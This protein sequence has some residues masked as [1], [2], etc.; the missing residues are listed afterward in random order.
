MMRYGLI[1]GNGRFPMLTLESARKLGH[2]VI[3]IGIQEEASREIEKLATPGNAPRRPAVE[4][5]THPIASI[6]YARTPEVVTFSQGS[7]QLRPVVNGGAFIGDGLTVFN[8][9]GLDPRQPILS[10]PA[11]GRGV[12]M[13]LAKK[14]G[15]LLSGHGF[16]LTA[17]SVYNLVDQAY[18]LRMNA[19]IQQQTMALRGKVAH[20]DDK[21]AAAPP[22][23]DEPP[24]NGPQQ[25]P[26]ARSGFSKEVD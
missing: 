7:P 8:V 18:Q 1:A 10:N 2:E 13:S 23:A 26:A 17:R 25:Q 24:A 9:S 3:A 15:V 19:K 6:V 14:P 20:L 11:L 12:A 5:N 21:L 16:V 4:V 22:Q